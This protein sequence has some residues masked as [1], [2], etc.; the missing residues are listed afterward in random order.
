MQTRTRTTAYAILSALHVCAAMLTCDAAG[1]FDRFVATGQPRELI[2]QPSCWV[3]ENF[4][5]RDRCEV[6]GR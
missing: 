6:A 2:N 3:V 5:A 4:D 1:R